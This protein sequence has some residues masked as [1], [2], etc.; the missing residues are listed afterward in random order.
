MFL[1]TQSLLLKKV[2]HEGRETQLHNTGEDGEMGRIWEK[3]KA[4]VHKNKAKER[5]KWADN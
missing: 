4:L 3:H 1:S 5:Q 2:E